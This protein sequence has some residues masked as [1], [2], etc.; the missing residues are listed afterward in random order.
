MRIVAKVLGVAGTLL[1][2]L[3]I[4]D[5]QRLCTH[6]EFLKVWECRTSGTRATR[7][8]AAVPA[9]P[10]PATPTPQ[11]VAFVGH[12]WVGAGRYADGRWA[13]RM[14]SVPLDAAPEA[15]VGQIVTPMYDQGSALR[16]EPSKEEGSFGL[17]LG[18]VFPGDRL[19]IGNVFTRPS[20]AGGR[21]VWV[22]VR[23]LASQ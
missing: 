4:A 6:T 23:K 15:L 9:V 3:F 16:K 7:E 10:V 14:L 20:T 2:G 8:T 18:S 1:M 12:G 5:Y 22:E 17:D 19:E 11:A 13:S 21:S